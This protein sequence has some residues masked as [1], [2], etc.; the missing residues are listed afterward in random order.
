MKRT[1]LALLVVMFAVGGVSST[2]RA[3]D[4]SPADARVAALERKIQDLQQQ[5]VT[6]QQQ[7]TAQ[8]A[9]A[10]A[11]APLT[12]T[13]LVDEEHLQ[14]RLAVAA[15][16]KQPAVVFVRAP[17][18]IYC[19]AYEALIASDAQ[20]RKG[21]EGLVRLEIDVEREER[22]DLRKAAGLE[23]GQP[24]MMFF[25]AHGEPVPE[26]AIAAWHGD[27]SAEALKKS[28]AGVVR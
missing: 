1:V 22:A 16:E 13:K 2:L 9:R 11:P 12:W 23:G 25:D 6:L 17:W 15:M 8:R 20:L 27:K 5:L 26:A 18:C 19:K 3:E 24:K 21:F 7:L 4:A 14:A 28:L 10:P